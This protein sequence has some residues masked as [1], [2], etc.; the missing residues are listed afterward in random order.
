MAITFNT[1]TFSVQS[2]SVD[3]VDYL[4][5][6]S[7][8]AEPQR[9]RVARTLPKNTKNAVLRGSS[10]HTRTYLDVDG[11]PQIAIVTTTSSIPASIP[12]NVLAEL[13]ADV[14]AAAAVD[15]AF[16]DPLFSGKIYSF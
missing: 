8:L 16:A 13:K 15:A 2:Q 14:K 12:P 10:K 9:L 5:D 4:K 3:Y 1:K 6:G 11:V 7:T